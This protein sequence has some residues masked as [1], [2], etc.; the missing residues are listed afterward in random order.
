LNQA[1]GRRLIPIEGQPPD[2]TRL[3]AG[4]AFRPRCRRA[5]ADCETTRPALT[6]AAPGHWKACL[7]DAA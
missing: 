1:A 4:C 5:T 3:P 6:E 2:L 7:N